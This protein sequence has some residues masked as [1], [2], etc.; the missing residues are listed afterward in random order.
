MHVE[1]DKKLSSYNKVYF[2]FSIQNK[3]TNIYFT[4]NEVWFWEFH[5]TYDVWFWEFH[6]PMM[7][8]FV[9]STLHK[10]SD[11]ENGWF[12]FFHPT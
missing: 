7:L 1:T 6:L 12:L 2:D 4:T 8:D 3:M 5:L 11:C 9:F 10:M